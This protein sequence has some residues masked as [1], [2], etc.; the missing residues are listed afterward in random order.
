MARG[1][2][3]NSKFSRFICSGDYEV[4]KVIQIEAIGDES[5]DLL[6]AVCDD[7]TIWTYTEWE[8]QE[9][10]VEHRWLPFPPIPQD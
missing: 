9:G 6:M 2:V 5:D 3:D 7:G 4:R 10:C 8:S 1:N